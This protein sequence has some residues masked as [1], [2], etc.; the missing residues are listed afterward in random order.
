MPSL[1]MRGL[2]V[3]LMWVWY[4]VH[5]LSTVSVSLGLM[6]LGAT[7]EGA[8]PSQTNTAQSQVTCY[9]GQDQTYS[10]AMTGMKLGDVLSMALW[11][12]VLHR[13]KSQCPGREGMGMM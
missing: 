11:A 3:V 6:A 5:F 13:R 10:P 8:L 12:V 2:C 4:G 1:L 9:F 7:M